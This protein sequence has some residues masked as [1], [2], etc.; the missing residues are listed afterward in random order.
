[1][2]PETDGPAASFSSRGAGRGRD[3]RHR[4][5]I[6]DMSEVSFV[7]RGAVGL[8]RSRHSGVARNLRPPKRQN[9]TGGQ[10]TSGPVGRNAITP[11]AA[12]WPGIPGAVS[13]REQTIAP[14]LAAA[15]K[16]VGEAPPGGAPGT[17]GVRL[18]NAHAHPGITRTHWQIDTHTPR[19][20]RASACTGRGD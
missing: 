8:L 6:W 1:D 20:S 9:L 15:R 18:R 7:V 3:S 17:R 14:A 4:T 19:R 5:A 2:V 10:A 13:V 11:V 16:N 12:H